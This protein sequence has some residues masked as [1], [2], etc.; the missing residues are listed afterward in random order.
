MYVSHI[1][2][3]RSLQNRWKITKHK[4]STVIK[5]GMEI[6]VYGLEWFYENVLG[7][8]RIPRLKIY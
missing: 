8:T 2:G 7:I 3:N 5:Y 6:E 4:K 1:P